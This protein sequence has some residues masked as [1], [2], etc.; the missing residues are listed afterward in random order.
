MSSAY[1][2]GVV[3]SKTPGMALIYNKNNKGRVL[4]PVECHI[5]SVLQKKFDHLRNTLVFYSLSMTETISVQYHECQTGFQV[6]L[7]V[8]HGS[9]N[10]MLYRYQEKLLRLFFYSF[11]IYAY[12]QIYKLV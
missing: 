3:F 8:S 5:L 11:H 7:K 12:P 9:L 6:S 1:R 10:Q 4:I 2:H